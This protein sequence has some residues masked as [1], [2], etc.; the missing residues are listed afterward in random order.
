MATPILDR[1]YHIPDTIIPD[2]VEVVQRTR[3]QIQFNVPDLAYLFEVYN[4]YL[5]KE[6]LD[7][8]C[9]GCRTKVIGWLRVA[10]Q[11]YESSTR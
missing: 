8:N 7:M 3:N 10:V 1:F 11:Q 9:G 2:V 4:R 6:P 5:T